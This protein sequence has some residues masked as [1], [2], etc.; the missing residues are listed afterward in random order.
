MTLLLPDDLN[1][2]ISKRE[3]CF[4]FCDCIS[5][6]L[7]AICSNSAAKLFFT[8]PQISLQAKAVWI[9]PS[10]TETIACCSFLFF[11]ILR[12]AIGRKLK[13]LP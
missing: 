8:L 2:T 1:V 7:T 6:D 12:L 4:A 3:R 10:A 9:L 13:L 5:L 11:L